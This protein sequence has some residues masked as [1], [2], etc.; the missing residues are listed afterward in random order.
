[1]GDGVLLEQLKIA[2]K[3]IDLQNN[4]VFVGQQNN[5]YIYFKNALFV[6]FLV[7]NLKEK[8]LKLKP[9]QFNKEER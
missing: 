9:H 6:F 2:T 4:V 3:R 7:D 8:F 5:P 1:M